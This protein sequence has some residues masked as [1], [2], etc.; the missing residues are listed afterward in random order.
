M[1]SGGIGI[2]LLEL[3]GR[4]GIGVSSF[5]SVGDK[6]DISSNDLLTWWEQDEQTRLAVL[7]V[8]SFGNP[9][10]F[11]RT[12]RRVGRKMPVLTTIAGRSSAGQRAAVS[13]TA[14]TATPLVTQE[15]LFEQA[16]I[17]ATHSLSELVEAAA[18]LSCQPLPAGRRVGDRVERRRHRR[19][20]RGCVRRRRPHGGHPPAADPAA[21]G[22]AAAGRA[23]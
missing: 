21:A 8:E 4:L 1:Q 2:A 23:R 11:A 14:A 13:H 5:A 15:A 20:R 18:L 7:W 12:A 6:Y 19:A 3:F 22:R 16:G 9:R 17:I 10:A